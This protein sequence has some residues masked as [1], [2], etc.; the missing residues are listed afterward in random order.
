MRPRRDVARY[1]RAAMLLELSGTETHTIECGGLLESAVARRLVPSSLTVREVDGAAELGLLCFA[2]RGLGA[3]APVRVGPRFD[4]G[5]AL[6]RIGVTWRGEPA[7][8][9]IACDLDRSAVR[10]MG[11]WLV[12]Y[13]VCRARIVVDDAHAV[14]ERG[15]EGA[16]IRAIAG[17]LAPPPVLPR[18]LL[19]GDDRRLHRIPWRE[20]PAPFR[21]EATIAV[22]D[23]GLVAA[24]VG[25]AVRWHPDGV[26]H[27]GRVHRCG[28]AARVRP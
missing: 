4:Y 16:Q 19:V 24:T 20:D 5:E 14:I 9:A 7:W 22:V 10:T 26:V 2:M 28:I 15:S 11:A 21:R 17:D 12:R 27:R 3:S 1:H 6:W 18:P 8:F 25:A 23:T 13:P